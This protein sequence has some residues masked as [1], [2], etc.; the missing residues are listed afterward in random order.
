MTG[1][2][3]SAEMATI[4]DLARN[5]AGAR[6][7]LGNRV[8][9]LQDEMEAAKRKAEPLIR[10]ALKTAKA[11]EAELSA[12]VQQ[13]PALFKKPRTQT[14]EGIRVGIT[15]GKG[16]VVVADAARTIQLIRK[17]L[18]EEQQDL[19]IKVQEKLVGS[20]VA[21][22]P[23]A[24]LKRIGVEVRNSGD[25]VFIKA[26]DDELEKALNTLLKVDPQDVEDAEQ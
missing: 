17:Y 20:A 9:Q 8:R 18:P 23:V 13:H 11:A 6:D 22:L 14:F 25:A 15:K 24:E 3:P 7:L 21:K 1:N 19:L 12:A 10:S 4:Q 26:V 2:P 5:Y 16:K